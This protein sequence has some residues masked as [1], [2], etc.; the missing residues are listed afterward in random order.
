MAQSCAFEHSGSARHELTPSPQL[1]MEHGDTFRQAGS[2]QSTV[3][4]DLNCRSAR[5]ELTGCRCPLFECRC[6]M[7]SLSPQ[8]EPLAQSCSFGHS[9]SAR[10]DMAAS[11]QLSMERGECFE[12]SAQPSAAAEFT[13]LVGSAQSTVAAA[14][15]RPVV[16]SP[17]SL[18]AWWERRERA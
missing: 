4:A 6:A 3:A 2:A 18:S 7:R 1:S 16:F 10:Q 11:P 12:Q 9:G 8:S 14:F 15:F 13:S 5:Q 17:R